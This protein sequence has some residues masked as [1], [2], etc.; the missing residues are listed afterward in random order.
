MKI[1]PREVIEAPI[2]IKI[3][4][5]PITKPK[6]LYNIFNFALLLSNSFIAV[7]VRQLMQAGTSGKTQGDKKDNNP[8]EN[9]NIRVILSN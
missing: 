2:K 4:E 9:A 1:F 8:A 6:D 5:K 7:P 3:I